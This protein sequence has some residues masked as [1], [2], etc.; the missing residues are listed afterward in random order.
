[1]KN[2]LF[3][4]PCPG[5]LYV[6]EYVP[7]LAPPCIPEPVVPVVPLIP[8]LPVYPVVPVAPW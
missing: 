1:M 7:Y 6:D 5:L 2:Q 4:L 3:H 8:V